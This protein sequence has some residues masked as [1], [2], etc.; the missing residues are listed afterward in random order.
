MSEHPTSLDEIDP[1]AIGSR[2][3]LARKARGLTQAAA[4]SLLGVARTTVTA[5]ETGSRRPK[6]AELVRMVELYEQSVGNILRAAAVP[7]LPSFGVLL[8][9]SHD[10][11]GDE[12]NTKLAADIQRFEQLCHWYGELEQML[13]TPLPRR[14]APTY[15]SD[16]GSTDQIAESIASNE[17]NRLGLGDGPIGDLYAILEADAGLR[18]FAAPLA[19]PQLAGLFQFRSDLGGCVAINSTHPEARRRWT[20]AHEYCHFLVDR[21]RGEINILRGGRKVAAQERLADAFAKHFLIPATGLGRRFD[22]IRRATEGRVSPAD[23]LQLAHTYRVSFES[24]MRRLEELGRLPRGAY[25]DLLDRGFRTSDAKRHVSFSSAD[26]DPVLPRRY[27]LLA[28]YAFDRDLI[29]EGQ[30]T[31][32]LGLGDDRVA[33]R[34]RVEELIH[35]QRLEDGRLL[36]YGVNLNQPLQLAGD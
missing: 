10:I 17:R 12:G 34:A 23:V 19:T 24:L 30:L 1:V 6:P 22:D 21:N 26:P 7:S 31:E 2:L 4:A 33:A 35:E 3:A 13:G 9:S 16:G 36:D 11:E 20:L 14:S 29:T 5:I 15:A 32:R 28:A 25:K 18:V 27:E 8:R